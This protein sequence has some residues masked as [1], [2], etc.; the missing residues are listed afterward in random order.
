MGGAHLDTGAIAMEGRAP[1]RPIQQR[2]HDR[3]CPS[4]KT[5][6]DRGMAT[7]T[8]CAPLWVR[9][10]DEKCGHRLKPAATYFLT[11]HGEMTKTSPMKNKHLS[12]STITATFF[13][14][15]TLAHAHTGHGATNGFF[16]GAGH[17]IGGLDHLLA[18]IAVGLWAA[19]MGGRAVWA[20]PSA[21]VGVMALGGVLGMSGVGLPF[22]EQGIL[23][24]VVVLGVLIAAAVTKM[25]LAASAAVVGLFALFHGHAHGTEMPANTSGMFYGIGF[26][27]ST[28]LLH[29][30]GIG[31]GVGMK[32]VANEKWVRV[33]GAAVVAAGVCL[34]IM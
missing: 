30:A 22:V 14:L 12:I 2:G 33:A 27:V 25:P 1:S 21:F 7:V 16:N 17:P 24:S 13:L 5:A 20:V 15:P 34:W 8:R 6:H 9:E 26:A 31:L 11:R 19:Q 23:L 18:M 4:V 32:K 10:F 28:V 29:A 3:A